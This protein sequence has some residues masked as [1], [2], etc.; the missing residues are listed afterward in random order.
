[1]SEHDEQQAV[2]QYLDT[3]YPDVL[4]HANPNG[5]WLAGNKGQRMGQMRKL[6]GEGL[7]P[8]VSDLFIA[9]PRGIWHGFYLEMKDV[10]GAKPSEN[11]AWFIAQ[12]EQRGYFT[13]VAYGFD[14]A[15]PLIDYYLTGKG[16]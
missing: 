10:G 13:A 1:M 12:A 5:A 2:C 14:E 3:V 9:E 7:L 15:K 11:Q 4:Y 6:K 16:A 8:G